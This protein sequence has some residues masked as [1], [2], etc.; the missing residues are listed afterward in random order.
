MASSGTMHILGGLLA[1]A[2]KG[3]ALQHEERRQ[4]ALANLKRSWD[5][6]DAA[7]AARS[8]EAL[9][10]QKHEG[11]KE[12]LTLG[13]EIDKEKIE[14]QGEVTVKVEAKKSQFDI[15]RDK[16]KAVNEATIEK[17]KS[18]LRMKEDAASVRLLS[19]LESSETASVET[20]EDG[21]MIIVKKGGGYEVTPHKLHVKS[22]S[23]GGGFSL[24]GERERRQG[25]DKAPEKPKEDNS[26]RRQQALAALANTYH[27]AKNN[28]EEFKRRYPGWF[29]RD[30][31]LKPMEELKATINRTYQ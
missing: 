21:T 17:L 19:Q 22:D 16:A 10:R 30:G 24:S 23:E 15:D 12:L 6:E 7:A 28:P 4:L 27:Q 18:Q 31:T 3:L 11:Q 5:T 9:Q 2:G 29:N 26:A 13:G 20:A 8:A 1:G 14:T 25:G